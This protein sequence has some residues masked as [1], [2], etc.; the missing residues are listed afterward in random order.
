LGNTVTL[1]EQQIPELV[2]EIIDIQA[3]AYDRKRKSIMKRTNKKRSIM[4]DSS[5]LFTTE[6][7][8][9]NIEHA[10][11]SNL[12]D[13]GMAIT[14][15]TLD[16][17]RRDEKELVIALEELEHLF[18]LEKYYQDST[19]AMMFLRSEFQDSYAKFT[20]ERYLFTADID[21]FQEDTLMALET[22][23]DVKRWY[24]KDHQVVERIY[25]INAVQKG[26]DAEE[27]GIQALRDNI[28]DQIRK[29]TRYWVKMAYEPQYEIQEKWV[30]CKNSWEKINQEM[31]GIGLQKFDSHEDFVDLHDIVKKHVEEDLAWTTEI[32]KVSS[33]P[34]D[35][36]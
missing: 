32:E 4:L 11:M 34:P 13:T 8:L 15:V 1:G 2:D 12:I 9:L 26:Q 27:N 17:A 28:I 24:E 25:Y 30:E 10:N 33:M 3:I 18:H 6:E 29:T 23:K 16:R 22:L 5:I 35:Q 20:N 7:K 36:V 14:D 21:D 19:Q 31:K